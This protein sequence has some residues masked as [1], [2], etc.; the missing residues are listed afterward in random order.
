MGARLGFF[1]S[2]IRIKD[3]GKR[4]AGDVTAGSL[5]FHTPMNMIQSV[6]TAASGL[7]YDCF[8]HFSPLIQLI[9]SSV[10]PPAAIYRGFS[11]QKL[12]VKSR[13]LTVRTDWHHRGGG[14]NYA[15]SSNLLYT[16]LLLAFRLWG[17]RM[18]NDST[19]E[20]G[21]LRTSNPDFQPE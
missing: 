20:S 13:S 4:P 12:V 5:A 1:S 8:S 10:H 11:V 19:Q 15:A 6:S 2:Q 9:P 14:D 18:S 21:D 17:N 3:R 7:D 16:S